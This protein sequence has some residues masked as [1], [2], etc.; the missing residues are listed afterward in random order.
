[1][2]REEAAEIILS[3][4][5][6]LTCE[7]CGG[8]CA[9]SFSPTVGMPTVCKRCYGK[10]YMIRASYVQACRVLGIEPPEGVICHDRET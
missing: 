2:T 5:Y 4:H 7:D 3:G 10:G 8:S 1:M 6:E 9:A